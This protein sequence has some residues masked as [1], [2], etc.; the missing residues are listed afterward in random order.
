MLGEI[1]STPH[2]HINFRSINDIRSTHVG[3]TV[4]VIGLVT[5]TSPATPIHKKYGF[6]TIKKTIHIKDMSGYS[7]DMTLC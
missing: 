2:L 5:T 4:D 3:S 6:E 7:M 1:V